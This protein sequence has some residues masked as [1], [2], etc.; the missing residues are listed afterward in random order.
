V[1]NA[2]SFAFRAMGEKK[3]KST[4]FSYDWDKRTCSYGKSEDGGMMGVYEYSTQLQKLLGRF[5]RTD[6][7][8]AIWRGPDL[9]ALVKSMPDEYRSE[10]LVAYAD[11]MMDDAEEEFED[12]E[13]SHA[14]KYAW[15]FYDG[16]GTC[17]FDS[18]KD[19]TAAFFWDVEHDIERVDG[20]EQIVEWL[21]QTS[22]PE[23]WPRFMREVTATRDELAIVLYAYETERRLRYGNPHAAMMHHNFGV[24]DP[25]ID[26][27]RY[28]SK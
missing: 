27:K 26:W 10:S 18:E 22:R 7:L 14:W 12:G 20:R 24:E 4:G 16:S 15:K 1:D 5:T 9:N 8:R 25:T 28:F 13:P 6:V 11:S 3:L 23:D 21:F 2:A 19:A 17:P